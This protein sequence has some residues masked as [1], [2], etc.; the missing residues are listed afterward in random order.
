MASNAPAI[1]GIS[2]AVSS[3]QNC[4]FFDQRQNFPMVRRLPG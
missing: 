1:E 4:R 2:E 3:L